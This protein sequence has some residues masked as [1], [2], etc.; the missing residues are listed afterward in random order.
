MVQTWTAF[1]V[2]S[3][4]SCS[5]FVSS[6]SSFCTFCLSSF[7]SHQ[8][9]HISLFVFPL[10]IHFLQAF[11]FYRLPPRL[12]HPLPHLAFIHL[13]PSVPSPSHSLFHTILLSAPPTCLSA[14]TL[15]HSI[16]FVCFV[17]V[18]ACVPMS[19]FIVFLAWNLFSSLLRESRGADLLLLTHPIP[20]TPPPPN[21]PHQQ[22]HRGQGLYSE[23]LPKIYFHSIFVGLQRTHIKP[24]N[25][26]LFFCF[27]LLIFSDCDPKQN[28]QVVQGFLEEACPWSQSLLRLPAQSQVHRGDPRRPDVTQGDKAI[29]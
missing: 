19:S 25:I 9:I 22:S 10:L 27:F 28:A 16:V 23:Q 20:D 8:L 11:S 6:S 15:A 29:E 18:C 17:C 4:Q 26:T 2:S 12:M 7:V 14:A 24:K 1:G 5:L 3:S 21:H 13:P